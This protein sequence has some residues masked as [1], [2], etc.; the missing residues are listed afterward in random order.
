MYL[1]REKLKEL[2][3]TY[4][5]G[6]YHEFARALGVDVAQL[7]RVLNSN[8]EAGARFLGRLLVFCKEHGLDFED[9]IVCPPPVTEVN[10]DQATKAHRAQS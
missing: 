7:H 1:R 3:Q 9:Y 8:S 5:A 10:T 6:N 4:A 2:L